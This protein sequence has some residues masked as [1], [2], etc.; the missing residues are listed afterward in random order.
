MTEF[1]LLTI[2]IFLPLA[3]CLLLLPVWNCRASARPIALGVGLIELVLTAWLY[4]SWQGLSAIP[5]K[6]PGYLLVE[7]AD[8][9]PAFGIRYTLGLD[10]ISLL[11]IM[12]TAFT[13]CVALAVSWNSITEKTGLFLALML[14]MESGIMGVFLS[15]DLALFYL[16][17]EVMLIPM[18]FLIGVW[19]HGRKIYSTVKFFLFTMFGSLLMLLA[20][21]ALHLIHVQQSGVVTF[22]LHELL[23]TQLP[24][25]TQLWLFG[26]FFLAFAIKFPLFPLHT[27]LPD[28]H[29]DAPTAGSVILAGLLL[30]TG[31]YGLIRFGYPLFPQAAHTLTPLLY[32]LAIIGIIYASLVAFAQEDMKRLI[33][34]SSIGH[35]GFVALGIAVWQPVALSGSIIQMANHGVTTGALFCLVGM[36]DERAHTREIR[37][38]GGLWGKIPLYSFFFLFFSLATV[39]LPGLNNFVGEFLILAGVMKKSPLMSALAFTGI[40]LTLIYTVRL[41][42]EVLF[43][44]ERQPLPLVDLSL[45]EFTLLAVLALLDL[46]MGV[47]PAPLLDMIHLPVQLLTGGGP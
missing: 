1:P 24:A 37:S 20:I 4:A 34:Y 18:F 23:R 21:V 36:L 28:A 6:L 19:G 8:W 43:Q 11:M 3:G 29:T 15:L 25:E 44:Q 5:A 35:M 22:G 9:I 40:V 42:Q 13:F 39:G 10:G 31:S 12:L 14:V 30:K 16:F 32:T 41:V 47:H 27:W 17:W 7:D 38:F 33:A 46:W 2:L 45:R 26:A